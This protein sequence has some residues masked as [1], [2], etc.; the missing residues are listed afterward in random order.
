MRH[1]APKDAAELDAIEI[2]EWLDS[3][4]YVLQSGG[5]VKV[6]RL[7]REL[8]IHARQNGVKLPFT[9][10]TPYINTIQ[11]DE[12]VPMPGN[13]DV[14][15]RIKSLVR[16]NALAMVV[17]ANKAEEGI[18]GH[19]STYASAATLYEVAFNHFF[20]GRDGERD[21]DVIFFQGHAAPGIYA[22]A[23]LEGRIDE[24]HL[25]N[26]RREL[27]AGGGLSSYPHPWLM[28]DFWEYPT[29]SM[30]LGPLM[31]IYHA[32]FI[33][34]MEDRGLMPKS[35]AKVWAFVGDGETDEPET[36]GAIT[37]PSR[38]KL[39][40]LIFVIN[41]NLQRLDGPV[42]GNG[43]IIQELEAAFRGAG[44]NVIKVLWGREWD[45]LL[46]K[47]RDG[48]LVRRMGEI[49]DGQYQ[50]Y[51][52]E[53]G[54]YVRE[55]FWGADPRLLE[56]VKHLSDD[57]LKKLTLGG[58]DPIKVYNAYKAAVEHKGSPTV[59]LA[60]TIKGYGLGEAG[61]GKNITHQQKKMNDEELRAF[62]TRFG[63]PI[64]DA[65]IHDTPFYRPAE[66]A[67]E[68][69]YMRERRQS[70]GG[71][72]PNRKVRS[73]PLA[74]V[75]HDPFEEF[76][77][78]TEGRKA[79]TT[80]VFVRLLSKLLRDKDLGHLIVPIVPDEARTFGMEALFRQ[81]GIYSH[82][83]QMYEPVDKDMLLYYKEAS[84]GQILEEGITEAG[85]MSSFIAAGTSYATHGVNTIPFFIYY[86]MF[87]F[88]R[89]G[90]L[91]WAAADAR[92]RGFML[93][94]TA[95]RT[96]LAGEGLQ[97]Q[98]GN[99]H[100]FAMA[101]PNCLAYD[102]AFAYEMAVIIE[103][104]IRRMYVEQESIFY[105]LTAM[106]EQYAMP[107]MP[108]GVRDGIVK[109]L[110]RFRATSKPNAG[111][112]AQLFGSGAILP[113]V[114]RAQEILESEYDVGADVWSVTSYGELYRDGHACERWNMLHP[115]DTP[116]VPYVAAC[117]KDA[118]GVLVAASD[119]VK[120]LPDAID[121][122]LPRPLVALGTDGFGRSEN[123]I[124]LRD[125]F[126]VDYRYVVVATLATLA[127]NGKV[128]ASVVQQAIQ[129]YNINPD[130]S[131]P[132]HS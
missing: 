37:L 108:E 34:Y 121:R 31:A 93:G 100:L 15:R 65:E 16:W 62:R 81:V 127:R 26:F 11:A 67:V 52:V 49:V 30:G 51:G 10:N 117:L 101:Y 70:L 118:P 97:H 109:G 41:C 39:D 95:G 23:Y 6:A 72:V 25:G 53:S 21:G 131:N 71:Y 119:Y 114:V 106:N 8:V 36:L 105:Y 50:K 27:N 128:D 3:L 68:I 79:S 115:G 44:W 43:Q 54:A 111:R 99:S 7:L 57:Q 2:R 88:Q 104:G 96:T 48:V 58:H 42:R 73:T 83:G 132:A 126:E 102:P 18:G 130:K 45:A 13:P 74:S 38:E 86:S 4:D 60:R 120:A 77:K 35:D 19:I 40:N 5:P 55:H 80:M 17:R 124:C 56:M 46:A 94:G 63:I 91:I 64:S 110:Y 78:G 112:R 22:R 24:T 76:H 12:Q 75:P 84:D 103:D 87:G 14:E 129:A 1:P 20:R 107:P 82:A 85:S 69:T 28:P 47:D 123:R 32:R 9:A 116:R 125:F 59:I 61:E 90:D 92:T 113:E 89:I 33:R 122:W 66:D 29:V 98:D